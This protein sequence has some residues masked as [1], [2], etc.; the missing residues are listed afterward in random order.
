MEQIFWG[1]GFH[2]PR[3][4]SFGEIPN[5][6]RRRKTNPKHCALFILTFERQWLKGKHPRHPPRALPLGLLAPRCLCA[7]TAQIPGREPFMLFLGRGS[8][9]SPSRALRLLSESALAIPSPR[10]QY[11]VWC[12][13]FAFENRFQYNY[14]AHPLVMDA[15][16]VM[17]EGSH[18]SCLPQSFCDYTNTLPTRACTRELTP[19]F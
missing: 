17:P 9:L 6:A 18:I 11:C 2:F 5:S 4:L 12:V 13:A 7:W 19:L 8:F 1:Y 15:L 10:F 3:L 16:A 14:G